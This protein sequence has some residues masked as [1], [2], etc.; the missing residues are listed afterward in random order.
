MNIDINHIRV[1]I[2]LT[3]D[4]K[5]LAT[6]I[7]EYGPFV[8]KGFRITDSKYVDEVGD[9]LWVQP[10]SYINAEKK[11]SPLFFCEDK[12]LWNGIKK[13]VIEEYKKTN[14]LSEKN[15]SEN[16]TEEDYEKIDTFVKKR[17]DLEQENSN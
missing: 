8:I 7:V 4:T 6:A 10:P 11:Y 17:S 9:K 13:K 1:K 15:Q 2:N 14:V 12:N 16:I 3:K 5:L